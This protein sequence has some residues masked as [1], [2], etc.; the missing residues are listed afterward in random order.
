MIRSMRKLRSGVRLAAIVS[1][2]LLGSAIAEAEI[3][4]TDPAKTDGWEVTI[5]G[6]V[7]AYLSWTFGD[8]I[9]KLGTGN[10]V[11]SSDPNSTDR[12]ILIGPQDPIQGNATPSGAIGSQTDD[13]DLSAP[14][15][16]GGFA[17]T[18][19]AFNVRKQIRPDV[20]LTMKLG[21]WG[22]ISNEVVFAVRRHGD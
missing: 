21:F 14:R 9:N 15:V 2:V 10:L 6:Q 4:L 13:K 12:Y 3:P 7:S 17:S 22:G 8:T 16:R 11:P 5:N 18:V 1:G 19:L 20:K